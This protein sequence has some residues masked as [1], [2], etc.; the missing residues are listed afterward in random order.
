MRALALAALAACNVPLVHFA[1]GDAGGD[2]AADSSIDGAPVAPGSFVWVRSLSQMQTQTLQA[3][4]AGVVTPGYLYTTANLDGANMLTSAGGAD[5]VIAAFTEKDA[6]NLYAVRHGD[7]GNEFGLLAT[8]APNGT[9][10]VSG[11]S[12]GDKTVD[13]GLGPVSGGGTPIEDG[14][15]GAYTN[16]VAGWVQRIVGPG[17]DKFLGSARGPS[18]TIWGGGWFEQTTNFNGGT[19]T[20]VGGRDIILARFNPFGGGVDVIKQYGGTGRDEVSG[21]GVA[22]RDSDLTTFVMAGF[23]DDTIDFGGVS[24]PVTAAA[25]GLDMW[26]AKFDANGVGVW[27][28][29]YGGPGDDRDVSCAMDSA[30]DVY[31]TGSFT[32]SIAFGPTMLSAVG[33]SGTDQFIA[34][35]SGT[36]GTPIWAIGLGTTGNET[37]GRIAVDNHGHLAFAGS[38]LAAFENMPT[39]GG[40]D[41][42][43]AEF[44]TTDGSRKW[45]HIFSTPVDDGVGGV[46]Y[47]PVTGDLF[48]SVSPGAPYDFGMPIIGDPDPLDVLIRIAP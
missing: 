43:V 21:G 36:D 30:G 17:S 24:K 42:L 35:L 14:Y 32:T 16:G 28:V 18:S 47:G 48:A 23:Y 10:I 11:V 40:R 4:A 45:A 41:A 44:D 13:L 12:E 37:S 8:L 25:G 5:L 26:I 7:V 15:I 6:T 1:S 39:L 46:V 27:A 2:G 20:S 38:E 29:T 19:L 34:K 31:I 3:G 33:G 22:S 9:P